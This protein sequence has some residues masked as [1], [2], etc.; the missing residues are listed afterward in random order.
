MDYPVIKYT[1]S[2]NELN[3]D[4]SEV[5]RYLGY[6]RID[7]NDEVIELIEP[8]ISEAR[9]YIK[10]R[11]CYRRFDISLGENDV[12]LLP[13]GEVT[14]HHLSINLKGCRGVY[15]MAATIGAE[16]D[17]LM[18]RFRVSSMARAAILQAI[19]ATAVEELCDRLCENLKKQSIG[20]GENIRA[21]YS[22]GFGDYG[23]TNQIGVFKALAPEKHTG[24]TLN[25][26]LIMS[27]EKSVTAL[28]GIEENK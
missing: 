3:I 9:K 25:D 2:E 17:R 4:R 18:L 24:I 15:F 12:I 10:P 1:L 16:F 7:I 8:V 19:G 23:L 26:S 27:P 28:I 22:P 21:R 20:Q 5:L 13:Y 6:S 11:A 14:S